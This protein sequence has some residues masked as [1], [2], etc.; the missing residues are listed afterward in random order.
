VAGR[1]LLGRE[2]RADPRP[3]PGKPVLVHLREQRRRLPEQPREIAGQLRDEVPD[4][5]PQPA[6]DEDIKDDDRRPARERPPADAYS[7]RARHQRR[8]DVRDPDREQE[9]EDDLAKDV[10]DEDAEQREAPEL[11]ELP[12]PREGARRR[13]RRHRTLIPTRPTTVA[14]TAP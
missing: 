5:Q 13:R 8:Q 9:P 10:D 12:Q 1:G 11:R 3:R 7:G 14:T 4:E 2:V 6:E